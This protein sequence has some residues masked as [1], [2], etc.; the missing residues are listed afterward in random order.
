MISAQ[1]WY[2]SWTWNL[3]NETNLLA[4]SSLR[5]GRSRLGMC[6]N[7]LPDSLDEPRLGMYTS[8]LMGSRLP[9]SLD[10]LR[11]EMY[12]SKLTGSE[13]TRQKTLPDVR[14]PDE[15]YY[16]TLKLKLLVKN[17]IGKYIHIDGE[18]ARKSS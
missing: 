1:N 18:H 8:K 15:K 17:I 9:D 5:F 14:L 11:L 4:Y 10:K 7:R 13:F 3:R 2:S 12:A 6:A 16:Q